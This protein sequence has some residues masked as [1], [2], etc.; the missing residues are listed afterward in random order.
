MIY[1]VPAGEKIEDGEMVAVVDGKAYRAV[2]GRCI[3]CDSPRTAYMAVMKKE[4]QKI[5]HL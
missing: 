5:T 2:P 1:V 3:P 4:D